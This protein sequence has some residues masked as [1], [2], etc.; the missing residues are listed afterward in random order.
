MV[1]FEFE[2]SSLHTIVYGGSGTGKTSFV[3][4]Y[5]KLYGVQTSTE[6]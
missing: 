4:Q 5:L 2:N 6:G 1:R 3:R